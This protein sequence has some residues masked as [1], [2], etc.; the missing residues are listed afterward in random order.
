[1]LGSTV[2]VPEGADYAV[3]ISGDSMEPLFK[4]ADLV[5]VKHRKPVEN[6]EIGLFYLDSG[7]VC[8]KLHIDYEKGASYLVS[9]NPKY[10]PIKVTEDNFRETLGKVIL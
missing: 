6:G 8:K 2:D 9:L 5:W 7:A 3:R 10:P 1:M 4:T